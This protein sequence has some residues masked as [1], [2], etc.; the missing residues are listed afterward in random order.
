MT[1]RALGENVKSEADLA[2]AKELNVSQKTAK[3]R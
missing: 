2:K 1:Y 3:G